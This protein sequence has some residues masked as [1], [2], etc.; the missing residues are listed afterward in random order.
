MNELFNQENI[1]QILTLLTT[2]AEGSVTVLVTYFLLPAVMLLISSLAW[3][4]FAV[5][6]VRGVKYC[7]KKFF[8]TERTT[9]SKII[10]KDRYVMV[11]DEAAD[12]L[13]T[14][15]TDLRKGNST[16]I[17]LHSTDIEWLRTAMENQSKLDHKH[18]KTRYIP[19]KIGVNDN[20]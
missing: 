1:S 20:E 6:A 12:S 16:G 8:D 14:L 9:V 5:V 7:V 4:T 19:Y 18:K 2:D 13:H 3:L 17:Y 11:N 15:L 10:S